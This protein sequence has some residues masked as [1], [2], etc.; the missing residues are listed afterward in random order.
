SLVAYLVHRIA[1]TFW[2][3]VSGTAGKEKEIQDA[4]NIWK[5]QLLPYIVIGYI[6]NRTPL[7]LSYQLIEGPNGDFSVCPTQLN[8]E[9]S[10]LDREPLS[11]CVERIEGGGLVT[12]MGQ[13]T[14]A[15]VLLGMRIA[16]ELICASKKALGRVW[17]NFSGDIDL[18]PYGFRKPTS[19][20]IPLSQ[21]NG[22]QWVVI[23]KSEF[24]RK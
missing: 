12:S 1:S 4:F 11:L 22:T 24:N 19:E 13:V 14:P 21:G 10:S 18:T 2:N 6:Q 20:T 7:Q 8:L 5:T 17:L 23:G 16:V 3:L 15:Q 9:I